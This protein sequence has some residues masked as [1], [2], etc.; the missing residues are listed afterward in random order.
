MAIQLHGFRGAMQL[1]Y[2]DTM[3][4]KRHTPQINADH[5]INAALGSTPVHSNVPCRLS[6]ASG[7]DLLYSSP[8]D[9]NR[10]YKP[11]TVFCSP[12][13]TIEKGDHITVTRYKLNGT[14]LVVY[15]GIAS[16]PS[17][18]ETHQEIAFVQMGVA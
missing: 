1:L 16:L 13:L 9:V 5:T 2:T 17:V 14:T 18:Y 6:L 7:N 10:I 12:D 4:V 3:V 8:Q 11:I 15:E